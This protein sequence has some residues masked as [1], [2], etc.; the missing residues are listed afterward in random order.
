MQEDDVKRVALNMPVDLN[1]FKFLGG[2]GTEG[3][4]LLFSDMVQLSE[5]DAENKISI[6]IAR[7][8]TKV[9]VYFE[10][11]TLAVKIVRK[12]SDSKTNQF[13]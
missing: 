12:G 3:N 13:S 11:T 4:Y 8:D 6:E 5:V 7:D 2:G 10:D 1:S 9:R